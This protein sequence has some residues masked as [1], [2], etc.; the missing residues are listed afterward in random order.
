MIRLCLLNFI[1][2]ICLLHFVP[3]SGFK[4]VLPT[5]RPTSYYLSRISKRP[6]TLL[7]VAQPT[8]SSAENVRQYVP[9]I[10]SSTPD[11][12]T[13]IGLLI[14]RVT[15]FVIAISSQQDIGFEL[16]SFDFESLGM[17]LFTAAVMIIGR[18]FLFDNLKL[19]ISEEIKRDTTFFTLG[20]FGRETLT[21]TA[22]LLSALLA[23][24]YFNKPNLKLY[25]T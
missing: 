15:C 10:K 4:L 8:D 19:N 13:I 5:Q 25:V 1:F 3:V 18:L 23:S 21:S 22:A 16:V 6:L 7:K 20:T 9:K 12:E 2:L 17:A 11:R 14:G 24:K